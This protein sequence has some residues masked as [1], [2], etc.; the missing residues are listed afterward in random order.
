MISNNQISTYLKQKNLLR[1]LV[2]INFPWNPSDANKWF[3]R[4]EA[5]CFV[6]SPQ[7]HRTVGSW[8][9]ESG[10]N[11]TDFVPE[12]E[13]V[14][15]FISQQVGNKA[16]QPNQAV[17][18]YPCYS[19]FIHHLFLFGCLFIIPWFKQKLQFILSEA[20]SSEAAQSKRIMS[21]EELSQQLER[22]LLEDM[23]SDEQIFDWVEVREVRCVRTSEAQHQLARGSN[24]IS[25]DVVFS[26]LSNLLTSK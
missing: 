6:L 4:G 24:S 25:W 9:R 21:P 18:V 10:L 15:T 5:W 1:L 17:S 16:L 8:W 3:Q 23:A 2:K 20:P 14:Q 11:W 22:F 19:V 12:G 13:D 26:T 7:S